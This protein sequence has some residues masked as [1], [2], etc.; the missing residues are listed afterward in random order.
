[1]SW[2]W[3]MPPWTP[4]WGLSHGASMFLGWTSILIYVTYFLCLLPDPN[5]PSTLLIG[6]QP[7]CGH[8]C[9]KACRQ[10]SYSGVIPSVG[11]FGDSLR[12]RVVHRSRT[13]LVRFAVCEFR[14]DWKWHL[15][16]WQL[17]RHYKCRSVCHRCVA[18]TV[19]GWQSVPMNAI[20]YCFK[21]FGFYHIYWSAWSISIYRMCAVC[22]VPISWGMSTL[23][24][25]PSL[26]AS[27]WQSST[28]SACPTMSTPCVFFGQKKLPGDMV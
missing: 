27:Q 12:Q 4:S 15:E 5:M 2:A 10:V 14:G 22:A 19:L 11:P 25:C 18:T 8:R 23:R 6:N 7:I 21:W 16:L 9:C 28:C 3:D 20:A 24:R 1:M 13:S 17:K 26:N